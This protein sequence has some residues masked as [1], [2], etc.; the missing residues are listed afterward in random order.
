M[1]KQNPKELKACKQILVQAVPK[2]S[3]WGDETNRKRDKMYAVMEKVLN[4][5]R[6]YTDHSFPFLRPVQKREAPNYYDGISLF[7]D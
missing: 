6:N 5:L 4:D 3:K 2:K 7:R 1:K